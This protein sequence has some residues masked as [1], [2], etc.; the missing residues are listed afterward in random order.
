MEKKNPVDKTLQ[1]ESGGKLG[2][3]LSGGGFRASF[4]HIGVLAQMARLGLLRH[5]EVISTVSG[6]SII[7]ALYYLHLKKL[8]E[9]KADNEITDQDY[10][11]EIEDIEHE[12]LQAVQ[13]N[14]RMRTFSNP[15]KNIRM[16]RASYSRSDR[17]GEIYDRYFY[18]NVMDTN[19]KVPVEMR[20]LKIRPE[21]K[22]FYPRTDNARRKA[23]VPILLIN[24]T[25][26]NTGHNWRFEASHMGEP[27]RMDD[28]AR[29]I[30]KNLRLQRPPSYEAI[31]TKQQN[32]EL[33]LAVAASACVPGL[34]HPLAISDLYTDSIRVQLVD[35]GV[36]D[37][38][39][40]QGLI[41][42][43][44][45]EFVVSDAS[46]QMGDEPDPATGIAPVLFRTN[47][48]LMDR[49][50]E[51][52]ISR[53]FQQFDPNDSHVALMH[54]R[55]GLPARE[56]SW[57]GPD[58]K[59]IK[60]IKTEP[61]PEATSM[62]FG[63]AQS[64]QDLLSHIRTDLDSFTE[65]EAYSL[66]LD[67]YQMSG[68]ELYKAKG[69]KE[70]IS[71]KENDDLPEL[72]FLAIAP[73]MSNPSSRYKKH[74]KV[75]GQRLFKLFRLSPLLTILTSFF[76]V[77]ILFILWVLLKDEILAL[78]S[79]SLTVGKLLIAVLVLLLGFIPRLSRVFKVLR[80]LRSPTEFLARLII[81][82][83]LPAVGSLFVKVHLWIFDPLFLRQGKLERLG[84][85]P[86]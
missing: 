31:I 4:F 12:F 9:E 72:D 50:R 61:Q 57:I 20:E 25:T 18:R 23:K 52:Q 17:I 30:D 78:F 39:G 59:P 34:F 82:G 27:T 77:G 15:F 71:N 7:G 8:L 58:G 3:A 66:M 84:R 85:P 56:A 45:T 49:V 22:D 21:G 69:I 53:L 35:G 48:I 43:G 1:M 51:E 24:A 10:I 55:K 6:G 65:I 63:V 70:M 41:D 74:L 67:G 5:I 47:S 46:G 54:L 36:H 40:I 29:E 19:N 26:L 16:S 2:L 64:V 60:E 37:N 79:R 75:G 81:R 13:R 76:A 73:W 83:L 33:G 80:F 68:G 28:L 38:Q 32:I 86:T 42:E 44:C 62:E 14:I 11:R